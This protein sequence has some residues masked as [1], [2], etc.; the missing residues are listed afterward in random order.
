M[1]STS[2][3]HRGLALVL[4][5]VF[6]LQGAGTAGWAAAEKPPEN[7]LLL[8]LSAPSVPEEHARERMAPMP[9]LLLRELN[10]RWVPP[11]AAPVPREI[12][13]VFPDADDASLERISKSLADSLRFM[14][15]MDTGEAERSIASA[16]QEARRFRIGDGTRPLIAE[17]FLRRGLLRLWK[18]DRAGAEELFARSRSMR[19]GFSP[20]PALFSPAFREVWSRSENRPAGDAELLVQSI[21]P[22]ATVSADGKTRGTTP[23]RIR[24]SAAGPVRIRVSLAGYQEAEKVGQWLPGDSESLEWVL[25]RDRIA[26]LGE[27]MA[28]APEGKGSGKLLGELANGAG[29][30]RVALIV[31]EERGGTPVARVLSSGGGG[32]DPVLLGEFEWPSGEYGNTEAALK[33]AKLLREAGWPAAEGTAEDRETPWYHKWWIWAFLGAVA[34]GLAAGGGGGGG[35]SSGGSSGTIGVSF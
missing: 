30:S 22:G 26:T 11:P 19:P 13:D 28:A 20:D 12:K 14:E 5:V 23:C 10:V 4:S 7:C 33:T 6:A 27:I 2:S 35:G 24:V 29:A 8:K 17:I 16:E 25:G 32:A 21:P 18:G 34:I 15:R 1:R 31:L 9:R 3:A